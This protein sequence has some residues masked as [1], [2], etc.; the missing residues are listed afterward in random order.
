MMHII[1]MT[2]DSLACDW[3]SLNV[4]TLNKY[5]YLLHL[6]MHIIFMTFD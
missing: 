6:M 4:S 1:F 2:F 5:Q 3:C